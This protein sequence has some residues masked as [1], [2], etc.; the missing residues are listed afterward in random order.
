ML[1][2]LILPQWE[3]FHFLYL[4][5]WFETPHITHFSQKSSYHYHSYPFD[6]KSLPA[7]GYLLAQTFYLLHNAV[8]LCLLYSWSSSNSFI[9][10]RV[11]EAPFFKLILRL[12]VS[13]RVHCPL[14][15]HRPTSRQ[16]WLTF[17]VS[18]ST[19][20]SRIQALGNQ[21]CHYR[22]ILP[23]I[24]TLIVAIQLFISLFDRIRINHT[25]ADVL[26]LKIST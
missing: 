5:G 2:D 16:I 3:S 4:S 7:F 14:H 15:S 22:R 20:V 17:S 11:V 21:L 24:L 8:Q 23:I 18:N 9:S 10:Y 12:A 19:I 6:G 13:H 1:S 26:I 25:Q